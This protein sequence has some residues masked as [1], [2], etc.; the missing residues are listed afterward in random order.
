[1]IFKNGWCEYIRGIGQLFFIRF[2]SYVNFRIGIDSTNIQGIYRTTNPSP[3]QNL[4]DINNLTSVA[5]SVRRFNS[6]GTKGIKVRKS[7]KNQIQDLF[8]KHQISPSSPINPQ[9]F[10]NEIHYEKVIFKLF[11]EDLLNSAFFFENNDDNTDLNIN[12]LDL[13]INDLQFISK[14]GEISDICDN[15]VKKKRKKTLPLVNENKKHHS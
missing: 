4:I 2:K 5:N 11:S 12:D 8:G 13:A 7:Y 9:L 15:K 3:L 6:D 1:M 10:N 14:F